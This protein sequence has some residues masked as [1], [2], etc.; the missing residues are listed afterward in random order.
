MAKKDLEQDPTV[1][2]RKALE[3]FWKRAD[4]KGRCWGH[5]KPE[6]PFAGTNITIA[7]EDHLVSISQKEGALVIHEFARA[8]GTALGRRIKDILLEHDLPVLDE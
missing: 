3:G 4:L 7:F 8:K 6:N 2:A 1:L 5:R